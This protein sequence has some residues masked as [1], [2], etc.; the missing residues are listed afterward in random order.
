MAV[1]RSSE[2]I[3]VLDAG[4]RIAEGR[5]TFGERTLSSGRS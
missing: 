1:M 4:D 2:R 5:V 3:V